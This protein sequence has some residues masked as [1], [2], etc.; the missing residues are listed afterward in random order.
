MGQCERICSVSPH[1]HSLYEMAKIVDDSAKIKIPHNSVCIRLLLG[2]RIRLSR[3]FNCTNLVISLFDVLSQSCFLLFYIS[4]FFCLD[5]AS[6]RRNKNRY[7]VDK[8]DLKF[9]G[10][11]KRFVD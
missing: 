8:L 2:F 1:S 9:L 6:R 5:A 7:V 10:S 11:A 3:V 4:V